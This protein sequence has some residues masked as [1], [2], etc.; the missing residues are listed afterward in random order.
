MVPLLL[1]LCTLFALPSLGTEEAGDT[2]NS[3]EREIERLEK[4]IKIQK[5]KKDLRKFKEN[6]LVERSIAEKDDTKRESSKKLS[7]DNSRKKRCKK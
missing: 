5:L 3:P 4:Q 7:Q 1:P 2:A 6:S